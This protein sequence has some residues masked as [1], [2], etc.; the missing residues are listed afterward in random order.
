MAN[1]GAAE[2]SAGSGR[3]EGAQRRTSSHPL[4]L[5][6]R[7]LREDSCRSPFLTFFPPGPRFFPP[8][9]R[10]FPPP[11]ELLSCS[12]DVSAFFLPPLGRG[13]TGGGLSGSFASL[14][15]GFFFFLPRPMALPVSDTTGSATP[16]MVNGSGALAFYAGQW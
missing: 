14:C 13:A 2:L 7:S 6:S 4:P 15:S 9:P 10:F 16:S 12:N 8:G 5:R 1:G 3:R 11:L